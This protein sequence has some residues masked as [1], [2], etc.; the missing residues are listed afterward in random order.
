MLDARYDAPHHA[1]S[2]VRRATTGRKGDHV[3]RW[4]DLLLESMRSGLPPWCTK[5]YE[6]SSAGRDE[7]ERAVAIMK[8]HDELMLK[9]FIDGKCD[10][11]G[12]ERSIG[13]VRQLA[14]SNI[15]LCTIAFASSPRSLS[16]QFPPYFEDWFCL[17][18]QGPHR[19][20]RTCELAI[21]VLTAEILDRVQRG[22][23]G[24]RSD[25]FLVALLI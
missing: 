2:T 1:Y 13:D 3:S 19:T 18:V 9:A 21:H 11:T 8:R 17:S 10:A 5:L 24:Q 12:L 20:F 25:D 4:S 23:P 15:Q 16:Y 7:C 14:K 22:Q 6:P